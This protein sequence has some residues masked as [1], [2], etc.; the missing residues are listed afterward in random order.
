MQYKIN[1]NT[2][3]KVK[4]FSSEITNTTSDIMIRTEDRKYAIDARSIMAIFSLDLSRNLILEIAGDENLFIDRLNEL[5]IL[6]CE[7]N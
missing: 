4:K 6:L 7:V 2:F 5:D 3:D 1:L